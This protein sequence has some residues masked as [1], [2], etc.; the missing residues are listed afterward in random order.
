MDMR[1]ATARRTLALI[2]VAALL[3]AGASP[4][5]AGDPERG[6]QIARSWCVSCHVI[7]SGGTGTTVDAAPSFPS[8]AADKERSN[9]RRLAAWLSTSHP[10]MPD[11]SLARDNIADLVAYIRTLA[12]R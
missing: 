11:F 2:A 7:D 3:M 10:T 4:A 9:E 12:P 5:D 1:I 6:H 8:I